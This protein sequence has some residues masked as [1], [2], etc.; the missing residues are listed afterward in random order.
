MDLFIFTMGLTETWINKQDGTVYPTA[1]G[2]IAGT[3]D[4][5]VYEFKNLSFPEIIEDFREFRTVLKSIRQGSLPRFILTVS[6]VPLTG[7]ASGKHVLQASTYS[8]SVLR[9]AAGHLSSNN[10]NVD[11]FPSYEVITNPASRSVFFSN[12]LRS[13]L[14]SG[15]EIVMQ[16]FFAQHRQADPTAKPNAE[17]KSQDD[18]VEVQCEE[19]MLEAFGQ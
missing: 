10:S 11:Y 4:Q 14:E 5:S 19:A 12:N 7:T 15:V 13:V 3:F 1:P 17:P 6:P 9:A 18:N 16:Q 8:K 2:T